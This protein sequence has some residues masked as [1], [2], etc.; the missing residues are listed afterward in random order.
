[1]KRQFFWS[2]AKG[3]NADIERHRA[4]EKEFKEKIAELESMDQLDPMTA[5]SLRA[6]RRFLYQLELSK[7]EVVDKIGKNKIQ[8]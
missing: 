7:C 5:A 1:M 2:K 6:Y 4:K 3:L 8:N